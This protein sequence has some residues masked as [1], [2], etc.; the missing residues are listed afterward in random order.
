M[1]LTIVADPPWQQGTIGRWKVAKHHL[2]RALPYPMLTVEAICA[3]P[4]AAHAAEGAHLWLW[5]TNRHL[6]AAFTVTWVKPSGFGAYFASTTQHCLF[7][8]YHRCRFPHARWQPTHFMANAQR[9][10]QK[11]EQFFDLV[12]RISPAPRLELF[13]RRLR[14]GWDAW[15]NEVPST[16]DLH[17]IV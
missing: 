13:A 12:E 17:E 14:L 9:H 5:T 10:S 11:P 2:P 6:E 16:V 8:Y 7:G 15:G 1:Y 3:L 4:V